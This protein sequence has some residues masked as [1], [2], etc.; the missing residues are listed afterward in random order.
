[1]VLS[2]AIKSGDRVLGVINAAN[3]RSGRPFSTDDVAHLMG[4]ASQI[5]AAIE[6]TR[7][8]DLLKIA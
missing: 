4:L 1:M 2:L 7:R 3:R 8:F 5:A 6:G